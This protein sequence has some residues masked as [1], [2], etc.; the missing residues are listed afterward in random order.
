MTY[1]VE[2]FVNDLRRLTA[3]GGGPK[4]ILPEVA[5]LAAKLA[6]KSRVRPNWLI[7]LETKRE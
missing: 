2:A 3:E 5:P 4:D 6:L 7:N 1:S